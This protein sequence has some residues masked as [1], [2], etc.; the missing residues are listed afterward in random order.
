VD[1]LIEE[2]DGQV[3]EAF[4][5]IHLLLCYGFTLLAQIVDILFK[6]ALKC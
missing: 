1:E 6:Y 4:I 3:A 2:E 5:I